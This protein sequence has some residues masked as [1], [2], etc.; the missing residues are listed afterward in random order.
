MSGTASDD[1]VRI[2]QNLREL[3]Q[4]CE[5]NFIPLNEDVLYCKRCGLCIL[6]Q[7]IVQPTK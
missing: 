4:V 3:Q 5:H 6:I 7:A 2:K 1:G